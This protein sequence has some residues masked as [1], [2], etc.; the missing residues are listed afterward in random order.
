VHSW[1]KRFPLERRTAK[2]VINLMAF[3]LY[4]KVKKKRRYKNKKAP[5]KAGLSSSLAVS[6]DP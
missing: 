5:L 4:R 6:V 1:E 2:R 3:G